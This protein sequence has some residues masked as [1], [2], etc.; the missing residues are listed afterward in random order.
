[1]CAVF[2]WL[3][4][5]DG[6]SRIPINPPDNPNFFPVW[7]PPVVMAFFWIGGLGLAN[8][9]RKIPCVRVEVLPDGAVVIRRRYPFRTETLVYPARKLD[10]AQVVAGKDN[11]GDPYYTVQLMQP[12]GSAVDIAESSDRDHCESVCSRFNDAMKK[13]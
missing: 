8:F 13:E 1:M 2:T 6:A 10:P 9:L 7:F 3:F 12:D 4:I 11:D 5:R